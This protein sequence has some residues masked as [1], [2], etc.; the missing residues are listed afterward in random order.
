M[1]LQ[2][3]QGGC[4]R[5]PTQPL[6]LPS[7]LHQPPEPP[8]SRTQHPAAPQSSP[9]RAGRG[10]RQVLPRSQCHWHQQLTQGRPLPPRSLPSERP[11]ACGG[12]PTFSLSRAT[13]K[14]NRRALSPSRLCASPV[15]KPSAGPTPAKREVCQAQAPDAKGKVWSPA[16]SASSRAGCTLHCLRWGRP[17]PL[18]APP[19]EEDGTG[20]PRGAWKGS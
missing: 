18:L 9:R 20:G 2:Q 3:Q 6:T 5:P 10:R 8:W 4:T 7:P 1:P 13:R 15:A 11:A 16:L 14:F 19:R 12:S 17:M